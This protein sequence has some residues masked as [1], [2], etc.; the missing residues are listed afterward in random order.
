M[1]T[2]NHIDISSMHAIQL[3]YFRQYC[4][5]CSSTLLLLSWLYHM[6]QKEKLVRLKVCL[7]PAINRSDLWFKCMLRPRNSQRND[8]WAHCPHSYCSSFL[9]IN[10]LQKYKVK[11]QQRECVKE[12]KAGRRHAGEGIWKVF[13]R[14]AGEGIWS[15]EGKNPSKIALTQR[16]T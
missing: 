9:T 1:A 8:L 12:C 15:G 6:R 3:I 5:I 16:K 11:V 2:T 10:L 7:H 4:A 14:H 13:G